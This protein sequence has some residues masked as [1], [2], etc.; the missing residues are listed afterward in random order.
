[1]NTNGLKIKCKDNSDQIFEQ[2]SFCDNVSYYI[3][4]YKALFCTE[5]SKNL[6]KYDRNYICN[7]SKSFLDSKMSGKHNLHYSDPHNCRGSCAEPGPGC[8]ACTN[9]EYFYCI[10]NNVSVCM[11]PL[12]VC[13]GHPHCDNA[14]DE[15]IEK[16]HSRFVKKGIVS[17][18]ATLRCFSKM[19]PNMMTLA[20][21]CDG[22]VECSHQEDEPL[23]RCD[24]TSPKW[25]YVSIIFIVLFYFFLEVIRRFKSYKKKKNLILRKK[26]NT[27]DLQK[28]F[29]ENHEKYSCLMNSYMLF[30]KYTKNKKEKIMESVKL[31]AYEEKRHEN[32]ESEIF[33]CLHNNFEPII[34]EMVMDS[35]FPGI[36]EKYY[37]CVPV[38]LDRLNRNEN[39]RQIM[40]H[41]AKLGGILGLYSDV[42][43]D[44]FLFI[45]IYNLNGGMKPLIDYPLNFTSIIVVCFGVSIVFP[46]LLASIYLSKNSYQMI[47][48]GFNFQVT[49]G[50]NLPSDENKSKMKKNVIY[51]SSND[52]LEDG[53]AYTNYS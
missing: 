9:S 14:E 15:D 8:E 27:D 4:K 44:T 53:L 5:L 36:M 43:K 39:Y 24:N 13:D 1:M 10:R 49:K 17:T 50:C 51:T 40:Y 7:N 32:K 46:L 11:N 48:E 20:T 41:S 33:H 23:N 12:L 2:K 25:F 34:C 26:I 47:Y 31:F 42:V 3:G 19:H 45:T 28:K 35:N 6:I 30:V 18:Y 22:I 52:Q 38:F 29:S 21:V 16:C 37:S